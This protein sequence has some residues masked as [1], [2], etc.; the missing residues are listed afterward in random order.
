VGRFDSLRGAFSF[1]WTSSRRE[2]A[3]AEYIL[4]EHHRGRSLNEILD[5]RYVTNR[6]S[7]DEIDRLLERPEVVHAIGQDI[8]DSA[9]S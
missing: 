1:L 8:I 7:S 5:D 9:R 3:V 4:R 2:S 6:C